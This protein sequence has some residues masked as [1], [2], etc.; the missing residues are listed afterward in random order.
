M[1]GETKDDKF[2]YEFEDLRRNEDPV[3]STIAAQFGF[4]DDD[5][6]D[7]EDT[8]TRRRRRKRVKDDGDDPD[9]PDDTDDTDDPDGDGEGNEED[10]DLVPMSEVRK[11]IARVRKQADTNLAKARHEAE[12]TIGDLQKR[13]DKIEHGS[14][15]AELSGKYETEIERLDREIDEAVE[16]GDTKKVSQLTREMSRLTAEHAVKTEQLKSRQNEHDDPDDLNQR[17]DQPKVIPRAN[18]WLAEQDWWDDPEHA[19]VKRFVRKLDLALQERG[20]D[21]NDD[22]F[23]EQLESAIEKKYPGVIVHTMDDDR[24][25]ELEDDDDEFAEIPSKRARSRKKARRA[26]NRQPV[27]GDGE[28]TGGKRRRNR[29]GDGGRKG[30]TLN[31]NQVANMRMFG[32]DPNN[33]DHVEAYLRE[34]K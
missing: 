30:K 22:D 13:V 17:S 27:G 5:G 29:D 28:R 24:D 25:P 20:Y 34:I 6:G 32:M 31:R 1:A 10:D 19:R 11:R 15:E 18:D 7:R 23:Y 14:E 3:P 33:K 16:S 2:E 4:E 12:A 8:D 9:D 21:P 26:A